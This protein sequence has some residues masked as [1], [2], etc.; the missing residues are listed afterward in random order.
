LRRAAQLTLRTNQFNF[1]TI[2]REEADL[3]ALVAGGRH[4]IRTVRVRDR[5]GDYGLVGLVIAERGDEAWTLDTFLLSCRVLG[6]GVEHRIVAELGQMA[7]EAGARAVKLRVETTKRNTPARSFV[8]AIVPAEFARITEQSIECEVPSGVLAAVRFEPTGAGDTVVADEQTASAAPDEP[9][10]SSRVRRREQQI[11]RAAFELSTGAAMRAAGEGAVAGDT[12]RH[13]A[14]PASALSAPADSSAAE[15]AALVHAAFAK[16]LRVSPER[17][18]A[19]DALEA[20]GCDS[21]R[22]VEITVALSERFAWLPSTLLFEHRSVSQ[23]VDEIVR[24]SRPAAP[25]LAPASVGAGLQAGPRTDQANGIAIVGM[26]LRCAGA[27]SPED[28]WNLLSR[29]ES[30]VTPVPVTRGQFL[31]ELKDTRPHWAGLLDDV[32]TFDAE[33]FG[34]SPREAEYMDPQLRLFLEVAWNALEDAGCA[35]SPDPETGVFAGVMYSDYGSRANISSETSATPYRCWEGFS[36]ANR[37]SQLLGFHG[38]SLAVDTACSSSGTALHLACGA[39]KAGDCRVALVGGVNLILDPDRFASLGR[40][41]ILSSR[42]KCEPF[43]ADADGTVL[44]EGV[45]VVVLRPLADALRRGDRIYGVIKGTGL[46]TGSGTVGFTAPHPQAQADAIRRAVK[47]A[48]VDPR[49]ISYVETHG[50]GTALGDPIEVRGLTLAYGSADLHDPALA[51]AHRCTLGSIKPNIGHLEAG[52]GVLGLIKLLLQLHRGTLLPSMTSAQPNPQ[53]PFAQ[54]PFDVQRQL[55]PW[56]RPTATIDGRTVTIPRRAALSSF[57]VGGANAHVIVEEGPPAPITGGA[58]E[59]PAHVLALS[60]RSTRSLQQQAVRLLPRVEASTDAELA[61]LCFSVNTG[62]RHFSH[63]VAAP[64]ATRDE[65]AAALRQVADGRDPRNGA[66]GTITAGPAPRIA[67]LFTGQGSQYA[68]MGRELYETQPVF[69]E[70]LDRCAAIFDAQLG[71]PL[72]DLLFAPEESAE[73]E[74]LNQTGFTQPALFAFEYALAQLWISWGVR[75]DVVLGHSVGEIAAMC[76]AG[77]VTL[78]DGLRLIAARGRLMQALPAGG[79]MTS[80]MADEAR[81]LEAL[82]GAEE[83]V[84]IAAV[85]APGQVVISGAGTAVAEITARLTAD[86]IKTKPLTVSHAFHSPLMKPMLAE[87]EREVRQISFMP[88]RLPFVSCVDGVLASDALTRPDYW[89]RQVLQPVRFATGMT[90]LVERG[91]DACIEIGPQPVLLG[92]ARQCVPEAGGLDWLPSLRRDGGAWQTILG[93]VAK[94][95][96]R[97]AAVD[98]SAFD[99]PYQRQRASAPPYAFG[100]TKYWLKELPQLA[101]PDAPQGA[102]PA[103]DRE[104]TADAARGAQLY[105]LSWRAEG[106]ARSVAHADAV[107][108]VIFADRRGV[109]AELASVLRQDSCVTLV[110]AGSAFEARSAREY[111]IDPA[112]AEDVGRLWSA[113]GAD[114]KPRR[115]VHLWSLDAAPPG[116]LTPADIERALELGPQS[117]LRIV[118]TLVAQ[119]VSQPSVWAVTRGAIDTGSSS[120]KAISVAQT[121]L[122][123]FGRTAALE[124]PGVWGGLIDLAHANARD[125]AQALARELRSAG[126][127]DQVVLGDSGRSVARLVKAAPRTAAS[128]RF[129]AEGTYLVTGGTGALGLHVARWLAAHGA[130]HLALSSRRGAIDARAQKTIASLEQL[131][132]TV[133]VVSADVSRRE[134]VDRLFQQL[135]SGS[136]PLRGIVHAAGVDA[137]VPLTSM[138]D[139]D[140]HAAAAAKTTGAWLLHERTASLDLDLFLLFSSVASVLGSQGRAHYAAANAFLDALARERRRLGLVATTVNWGPWSGGGMATAEH[141]DQFA[142]IG[143]HGLDPDDALRALSLAVGG[144]E[145]QAII[146]D[147][148]WETFRPVYEARR[149]RPIL[150]ELTQDE[151]T[152]QGT[153]T[154]TTS[155]SWV[156]ALRAVPAAGREAELARLLRGEVAATLGFEDPES[157]ATDVDFYKLGIDSLMMA[158]LVGRLKKRVGVSCTALIFD[159]PNV[160]ALASQLLPRL[161]LQ[162]AAATP[163]VGDAPA[164]PARAISGYEAGAEPDILAFQAEAFPDRQPELVPSRWRWMFVDSAR[165]LGVDPRFWVYR[166]EGR[167]VGQMG[168]IPVRVKVGDEERQTGY[169]V[170]TM[171]LQPY[172]PHAVGSRLI[173]S[174]HEEQP[175]SLS[176]GQSAEARE[177]LFRLGWKQVGP[178]QIARMLVRPS[179]VLKGKLPAPAAWAAGLGLRASSTVRALWGERSHF[180]AQGVERFGARHDR[181]WASVSRDVSC[182]VVRDSSY[183]NWKYVDQPGQDFL[184]LEFVDDR[185]VA[186]VAVWMLREPDGV[187]RYRRAF[188]VDVVAPFSDAWTLQQVLLGACAVASDAGADALLCYH[189]NDRLTQALRR[190]GFH[191]REPQRFLLLDPS[192]L[193]EAQRAQALSA[194]AWLVTHGDSDIDRPW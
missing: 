193:T 166:D 88:P 78:E 109:G 151:T 158:D 138:S 42:G 1:T 146:A 90:A 94:L 77:G 18:A 182:G 25:T 68:G 63:R 144:N 64:V 38:P 106:D 159:H 116:A 104:L 149:A 111:A 175:F 163:A 121:P 52:A 29:G 127:E 133:T 84:A 141:L 110:F 178:L 177:I 96:A 9:V 7:A 81:V 10:D 44:G 12:D 190:C 114:A 27:D 189:I 83:L 191:L 14:T 101:R 99:A 176:L 132:A 152:S 186:G 60:A 80:V 67:F 40:L 129:S 118:Q 156:D 95:Y 125:A 161:S 136:S 74:L 145:V 32:S 47:A 180:T 134:D 105:Q 35:A 71:R 139:A 173:V 157:V 11:A 155:S 41:G 66:R 140:I 45:G 154:A 171:V 130:R 170:E 124:H 192:P 22:I 6:R 100:R 79:A 46:S 16:A 54:G 174:A 92:M 150:A 148:E 30:A 3:Q 112:N 98:W 58:V 181:L 65:A 19:V 185:G 82:A 2:R 39:L 123:G 188:L 33:F 115:I 97:G 143:N 126:D 34:V 20:L 167:I 107:H 108:W 120:H 26:H 85:N 113:L 17:V 23:I 168:S 31:H 165:R 70:A 61:D 137:T 28:L 184:R 89:V 50:T 5:F 73:A 162:E 160:R 56:E 179:N 24:L 172:R 8:S 164:G 117:V 91:V 49:T 36:L 131:G 13:A 55:A 169:L 43:G 135:Q 194:D 87:Y 37:L 153:Q 147:I 53:I 187:Y 128:T 93:S 4:D 57:G 59:R 86:G 183:L 62:R 69:R 76:V 103:Q 15:I 119:G 21:L 142:R 75:P 48:G 72:L 51:I 122:W 102:S